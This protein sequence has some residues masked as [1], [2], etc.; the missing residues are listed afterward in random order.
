[1]EVSSVLF[2]CMGNIC[3]SPTAEAVMRAKAAERGLDIVIDS[4]GTIAHHQGEAPDPRSMQAGKKRGLSFDGMQA[5]QV[6][7]DDFERFD[8]IL[9]ADRQNLQDLQRRCP[10]ALQHKLAL[11]LSFSDSD[12][13]EVPD[14]YYGAGDGFE[15][16]LD[17]LE[18][19]CDK[20]L[21]RIAK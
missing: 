3:R 5:R 1:M 17:L 11:I 9:A 18:E 4:A 10:S 21:D 7:P 15:L 19:S 8:L 2:V 14:P 13:T 16:V 12:Y 20:L 6:V